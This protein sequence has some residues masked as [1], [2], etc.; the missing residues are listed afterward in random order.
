MEPL[1]KRKKT[2]I[3]FGIFLF[4]MFIFTII[5]KGIYAS[6]LPQ[7]ETATPIRNSIAH[8]IYADGSVRQGRETAFNVVSG[9]RVENVYVRAGDIVKPGDI[10]FTI[11]T[12][13]LNEKITAIERNIQKINLQ[14]GDV[15]K[16]KLLEN[17]KKETEL[18]RAQEDYQNTE[19]KTDK[20]ISYADESIGRAAE[21]LNSHE[22][23]PVYQTPQEQREQKE[24]EYQIWVEKLDEL[25]AAVHTSQETAAAA[26]EA[27][28]LAAKTLEEAVAAEETEEVLAPLRETVQAAEVFLQEQMQLLTDAQTA[29][30]THMAN[31]VS[32]PDFSGEDAAKEQWSREKRQLEESLRNAEIAKE[33]AQQN[34]SDAMLDAGRNIE[35]AGGESNADSTLE[36]YR[37]D[38][39][40][41]QETLEKYKTIMDNDGK[42]YADTS[43]MIMEMNAAVGERTPD[44]AAAKLAGLD[45]SLNFF[46]VIDEEQ[47]KY[48]EQGSAASIN[49]M[50]T[51]SPT[52]ELCV[53]YLME[54]RLIPGNYEITVLL[55]EGTGNIGK[56]GTL[57]IP[58]R[59][60]SFDY[61]IPTDAVH[62]D[63]NS[64]KYVYVVNVKESIL[65]TELAVRTAYVDVLDQNDRYTAVES[66]VL[67]HDTQIVTY[68]SKELKENAAVRYAEW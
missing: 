1:K 40:A 54:S 38:L 46:A 50:G 57:V 33:T 65:G 45:Q 62:T 22:N 29:L 59:S 37:I 35:D 47:K 8:D 49:W 48:V 39:A 27:L 42:I 7:I 52:K 56:S 12:A 51:K 14:I 9:L 55:P 41:A 21:K 34:K 66:D 32:K 25:E 61:C 4:F 23:H 44:T 6:G 17:Q 53:D 58:F 64:K 31:Q 67:G 24:R 10:L 2:I 13:D 18:A 16:N 5:S 68:S 19:G 15:E 36:I 30:E 60:E 28:N 43:G 20:Q 3:A 11:D 63:G 26:Q